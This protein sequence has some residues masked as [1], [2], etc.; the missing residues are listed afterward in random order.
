MFVFFVGETCDWYEKYSVKSL[1]YLS[2]CKGLIYLGKNHA[3]TPWLCH[4]RKVFASAVAA[5][6]A[7]RGLRPQ[8]KVG[9]T[10]AEG[11]DRVRLD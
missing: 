9:G 4:L 1:N 10:G 2:C 6:L 11:G 3:Q 5:L 7:G 8:P